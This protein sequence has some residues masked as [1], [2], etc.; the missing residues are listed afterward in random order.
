V[1]GVYCRWEVVFV[2]MYVSD[3][4]AILRSLEFL[5]ERLE[6]AVVRLFLFVVASPAVWA[7]TTR[8]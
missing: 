3:G 4:S 7:F 6:T 5:G 8:P 2:V 1:R